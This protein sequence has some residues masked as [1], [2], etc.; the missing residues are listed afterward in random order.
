MTK[1]LVRMAIK[2]INLIATDCFLSTIFCLFRFILATIVTLKIKLYKLL[3][4]FCH[5]DCFCYLMSII[6]L[7]LAI[8]NTVIVWYEAASF[9]LAYLL[10]CVAMSFNS[11][12]EAW[13]QSALPV[14]AS[15]RHPDGDDGR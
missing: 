12:I 1:L 7:I 10:Y 5:R 13:A 3:I 2:L 11:R 9:L 6:I 15:W 8:A 4:L 14:P